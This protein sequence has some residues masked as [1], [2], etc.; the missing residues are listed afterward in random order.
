[1]PTVF[2]FS[3]IL[4]GFLGLAMLWLWLHD[5]REPALA[6][7]G[8]AR[9]LGAACT[10]MLGMRGIAPDWLTI[11]VANALLC[12]G[13]GVHWT[14]AR[15]FENRR[16]I[17]WAIFA[18]AAVWLLANRIPAF[19]AS[20]DARVALMALILLVYNGLAI[21]EFLRGQKLRPLPS[22]PLLI[23]LL[24]GVTVTYVAIAAVT[25]IF[26][27]RPIGNQLPQGF[28]F[29]AVVVLNVV[30]LAGSTLL[31][32]ALTKE[33]AEGQATAAL[34]AA[35]DLANSASLQK[36]RF[37][38]QMSH[39]LRTPLNGVLGM[40]Q[41]LAHDASLGPVQR[42]QVETLEQAGRHL[43]TILNE[44]LDI[45]RI[46]AGRFVPMPQPF[47]MEDT[48]RATTSLLHDTA[49]AK[50]VTLEL[51]LDPAV[52]AA[53]LGDAVRI[54]QIL[55]NLMANAIRFTPPGG[56]VALE[57]SPR[58]EMIAFAV[59]DNGSGVPESLR[60][61][62]FQE[63]SQATADDSRSGS[64]LGLAISAALARAMGGSLTHEDGME[65]RGS[66]FTLLLPLP[67]VMAE[68]T[69][70]LVEP[71]RLPPPP[72]AQP[73]LVILVVDDVA[74]NRMVVAALL[75]PVGHQV[76]EAPSGGAALAM[77][78]QGPLPDLILMDQHMPQLDGR[79]TLS[80]IRA[81]PG[82]AA[83]LPVI[84]L[85]A[86]AM[87]EQVTAML[88]A[89]FDGHLAKPIERAALIAAV[90]TW[91]DARSPGAS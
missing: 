71:A 5:R 85:T 79:E 87:P 26:A 12:V 80:R 36:T 39:E 69:A 23:A 86:D 64:G 35:R 3:A 33:K 58:E 47:R 16:P 9:L 54:R 41:A 90:A 24:A 45:S 32:I 78:D 76:V 59:I 18:A 38:S 73:G 53:M 46:E 20:I 63:F 83:T 6:S 37:L 22:R 13:Y 27:P 31:L 57:V 51:R 48:L 91:K 4:G 84:A 70:T 17:P 61:N 81:L 2:V 62:L 88:E 49:A 29:P 77:L 72:T 82:A 44:V 19:H 40:A 11:D 8:L 52:P 68:E 75:G 65:G 56:T 42:R 66:R 50:G 15:Q 74:A 89:G 7:W 14:G 55:M 28:M 10:I 67:H 25:L 30:F 43:L 34:A 21:L 1:M 60:P